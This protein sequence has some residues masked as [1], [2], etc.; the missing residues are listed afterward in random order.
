MEVD[1][2]NAQTVAAP[3]N[4]EN[5]EKVQ[6]NGT[7]ESPCHKEDVVQDAKTDF[8]SIESD[9]IVKNGINVEIKSASTEE[10]LP[11]G[12]MPYL[13]QRGEVFVGPGAKNVALLLGL[14]LPRLRRAQEDNLERAKRYALEQSIKHVLLKQTVAHQQQQQKNAMYSQALSLMSRVYVGSVNFEVKEEMIRSSFGAFGPIRS[15]NMSFDPIT[16]HH[17][18]F[19]FVEYEM[20]EAA[21]LGQEQMNGLMMGGRNIKVGRPSNM[22]QAQPIVDSIIVEAKKYNRIYVASIHMDLNE[23]DIKSVFEAF[24][25]ITNIDL[26]I[27]A[28]NSKHRGYAYIEY[29][30]E[31]SAMDAVSSMNL[32]DLGGQ[33]LRVC[34]AV[35]PPQARQYMTGGSGGALPA[36]AAVA[37]AQV[38]A[39][40]Q[41]QEVAK[42]GASPPSVVVAPATPIIMPKVMLATTPAG[43]VI[44]LPPPGLAIPQPVSFS[45]VPPPSI[46]SLAK[47]PSMNGFGPQ[48]T[49]VPP[50]SVVTLQPTGPASF[51][52]VAPPAIINIAPVQV[53]SQLP[54]TVVVAQMPPAP[55]AAPATPLATQY[56]VSGVPAAPITGPSTAVALLAPPAAV[57]K[58]KGKKNRGTKGKG[59]GG[60]KSTEMPPPDSKALTPQAGLTSLTQQQMQGAETTQKLL[61]SGTLTD[62]QKKKLI[63]SEAGQ[64]LAS[65]EDLKIKGNEARNI[66][67][68]KLMRR[69]ES[70]VLVLRN[71][72][73]PDDVDEALQ[74]EVEE[75]CGNYGQVDQVVIYQEKQFEADD[76]PVLVKIFVK[77]S[78]PQEAET[79]KNSMNGRFFGGRKISADLYDQNSFEMNNLS[80]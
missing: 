80:G 7:T 37:A 54:A 25:T 21:S 32:F 9:L 52:A 45:L 26:P 19:A 5:G 3:A 57:P 17:K 51:N 16:G 49:A 60:G 31:K 30:T 70:C 50:P 20:P 65:Q 62:E 15:I 47:S 44:S 69:V 59:G 73:G 14:G 12:S 46:V 13:D 53:A 2:I 48:V 61:Q 77:Y 29:E 24:G 55:V 79:A 64:S 10:Q 27:N 68:H 1:E 39:T 8:P 22:P 4:Q 23:S 33:Y 76:A 75:E 41:M 6:E 78:L 38:T 28:F 43:S 34:R 74:E 40:I 66:M 11:S 18:G 72:V 67:M 42:P 58:P 63:E 71:M 35:T 36:A 56:P